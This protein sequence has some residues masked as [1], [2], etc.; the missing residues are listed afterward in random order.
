MNKLSTLWGASGL[1]QMEV[2]QAFMIL[3]GL[4]LLF[5]AIRKG[6]EPLLLVPIGFGGILANIPGA[7]M[8]YSALE[9]AVYSG[10]A[11]VLAQLADLVGVAV[12]DGG[13][14]LLA[15]LAGAGAE[16]KVQAGQH[17]ADAGFN[18]GI[19]YL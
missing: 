15:A 16:V 2:G 3:I 11:A 4:L 5:L 7:G 19:L 12:S 10:D 1:A 17:V 18:D 8:A 9:N 14:E 13:K 6:F